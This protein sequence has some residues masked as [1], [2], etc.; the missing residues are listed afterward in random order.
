M[1]WAENRESGIT[2]PFSYNYSLV[3]ILVLHISYIMM[4]I[5][6]IIFPGPTGAQPFLQLHISNSI[7]ISRDVLRLSASLLPPS[8]EPGAAAAVQLAARLPGLAP[9]GAVLPRHLPHV[10]SLRP[11]QTTDGGQLQSQQ[12]RKSPPTIKNVRLRETTHFQAPSSSP[13]SF[14]YDVRRELQLSRERS[15][16]DS[17]DSLG[18]QDPGGDEVFPLLRGGGGGDVNMKENL[19]PSVLATEIFCSVPGRLSLLSS[20]SKYK[21]RWWRHQTLSLS[22]GLKTTGW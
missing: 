3:H 10:I 7:A 9:A 2:I 14:P 21:V 6:H 12:S 17:Q 15:S 22:L 5:I 8:P 19:L 20:T 18:Q 4:I 1:W 11:H 16:C 13:N